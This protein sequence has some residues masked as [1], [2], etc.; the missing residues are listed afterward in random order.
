E[1]VYFL[2][3]VCKPFF[4]DSLRRVLKGNTEVLSERQEICASL[5]FIDVRNSSIYADEVMAITNQQAMEEGRWIVDTSRIYVDLDGLNRWAN[6]ELSEDYARFRDLLD[7]NLDIEKHFDAL[8][9]DII[10]DNSFSKNNILSQDESDVVLLD[11]F[12]RLSDEFLNNPV[13]GL[14]FYLSKRIRHQSF[15]GLIRGPLEFSHI[16]TMQENDVYQNNTYWISKFSFNDYKSQ[17][18]A[19]A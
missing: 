8:L 9:N 16:I 17:Q 15:I 1:L 2:K 4:M 19:L 12:S 5:R 13:F 7:V 11:I 18:E 10:N 6:D 14:D 3:E